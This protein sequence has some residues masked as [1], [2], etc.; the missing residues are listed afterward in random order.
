MPQAAGVQ[1]FRLARDGAEAVLP[2]PPVEDG[3]VRFLCIAPACDGASLAVDLE[4]DA[5]FTA[6][7]SQTTPGLPPA[8]HDLLA[9]RPAAATPRHTGD[10]TIL[11]DRISVAVE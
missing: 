1:S 5:P 6:F 7:I 3:Y 8:D 2:A 11:V 9:A 4:S 10:A